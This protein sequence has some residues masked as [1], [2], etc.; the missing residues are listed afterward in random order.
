MKLHYYPSAAET[1]VLGTEQLRDRFLISG[2]FLPGHLTA[3]YTDL[4]RMIVGAAVPT[5]AP[6]SL[7]NAK[8]ETGTDFFL[9]RREIG[10][11]NVGA[12]GTVRV[13]SAR[14]ALGTLDCLYIGKG[15]KEVGFENG[16]AGQAQFY[17]VST[18]AHAK[19]PTALA[20]RAQAE[21]ETLGSA[22]SANR[23][24]ICRYIH[25]KGI[26]SCELVL[27]FT[28]FEAGS[29]W[30]TMPPHT[31]DRRAEAYFYFDLKPNDRVFHFMGQPDNMR[32]I[33][34]ANEEAVVSPPWSIHMGAG[35]SAYTFIWSM[36]GE[37]LDYTD[38]NV[39]DICQLR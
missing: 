17:F 22:A 36:G 35:T 29:V 18:S 23:R 10:I 19:F 8:E 34:V 14:H 27:G 5:A 6:L 15:E 31:H 2:L 39:L 37:N 25:Q 33:V 12:P 24:H 11:L 4:D 21:V 13:G 26:P 16:P 32:H 9:E 20:T 28:E 38:M 30:N 1:N 7:P 3:H